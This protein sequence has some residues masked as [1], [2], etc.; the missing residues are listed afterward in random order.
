MS[1]SQ[2]YEGTR[3]PPL[4]SVV[5]QS[6]SEVDLWCRVVSV[7]NVVLLR[8]V[9][10]TPAS[11]SSSPVSH[12]LLDTDDHPVRICSPELFIM[13]SLKTNWLLSD[14]FTQLIQRP[15]KSLWLNSELPYWLMLWRHWPLISWRVHC[16]ISH[17][18]FPS[19][20]YNDKVDVVFITAM[21][22]CMQQDNL[23]S[24]SQLRHYSDTT[25]KKVCKIMHINEIKSFCY[26]N[27]LP[28]FTVHT[29]CL[30]LMNKLRGC[31]VR[32][33]RY[34]STRMQKSSFIGLYSWPWQLI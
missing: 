6:A 23:N 5:Y 7:G 20:F 32:P 29:H 11:F 19:E 25:S 24:A 4:T 17:L 14:F 30:S 33:T 27:K 16:S 22:A 34:A 18:T 21:L 9:R 1:V 13:S 12:E 31:R 8:P 26:F 2:C 3:S 10:S 15:H 28:C